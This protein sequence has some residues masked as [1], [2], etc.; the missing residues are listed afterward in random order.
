MTKEKK[1]ATIVG[2]GKRGPNWFKSTSPYGYNIAQCVSAAVKE[3]RRNNEEA[4]VFW[5]HQV[6]ISGKEAETFLWEILRMHSIEDIGLANPQLISIITD[7]MQLYFDL[8]E[9]DDRKYAVLAHAV[10]YLTR[11]KKSRYSNELF[12]CMIRKLRAGELMPKMPDYA[13]DLHLPEGRAMG[14]GERHY[15]TE[16][17]LLVNEDISLPKKYWE[18]LLKNSEE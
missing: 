18:E 8:P 11:S 16:A 12:T 15:L 5:A 6:A 13:I 1:D 10:I 17:A 3:I 7:T 2:G 9:F 14:R 4:A